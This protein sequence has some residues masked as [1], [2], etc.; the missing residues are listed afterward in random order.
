MTLHVWVFMEDGT[1]MKQPKLSLVTVDR[2]SNFPPPPLPL[3]QA[4]ARRG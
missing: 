3:V 1:R 2:D 4:K